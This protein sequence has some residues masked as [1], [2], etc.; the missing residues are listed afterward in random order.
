MV[1]KLLLAVQEVLNH[2]A[3]AGEDPALLRRLISHYHEIR[4]GI[5]VHKSPRLFGAI[6]TDPYSHTPGFAGAQQPGMT[7]Q[8]KEDLISRLGEMG[9]VVEDGKLCFRRHLVSRN[10]FLTEARPFQYY[11][12]DGQ[13]RSLHLDPGTMVFTTCQVP[14]VAHQS[15]PQRIEITRADGARSVVEA[16]DLD[17]ATCAAIF[18]RTGAIRRLD[19]FFGFEGSA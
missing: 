9:V 18:E 12:F 13:Q 19:V 1:S 15:G 5:G 14:V 2:A 7:G 4:E 11:D 17:A 6:P 16:L 10:E 3:C 8:V